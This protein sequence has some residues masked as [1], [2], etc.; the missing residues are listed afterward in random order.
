NYIW[1][2][3]FSAAV[4]TSCPAWILWDLLT[5]SRYGF[6]DHIDTSQLDKWAFFAASK[7]SNELVDDGFGGQEIAEVLELYRKALF[8]L[9]SAIT[10]AEELRRALSHR[11]REIEELQSLVAEFNR[12]KPKSGEL[13]EISSLISRMESVE[14]LRI[15]SSGALNALDNEEGGANQSLASAKRLLSSAKSK[16]EILDEFVERIDNALVEINELN[17]ELSRY[18]EGLAADPRSLDELLNRRAGLIEA[19][20]QG[21][22]FQI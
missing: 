6:G 16:D 8:E 13:A 2:G 19:R 3:T 18:L 1:N 12:I 9:R 4:W 5:S 7:Y 22:A 11:D 14:E 17:R 10:R 20:V 21:H 15:A